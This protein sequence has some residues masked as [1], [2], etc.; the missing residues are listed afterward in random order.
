MAK[1]PAK[2]ELSIFEISRSV[3]APLARLLVS[4]CQKIYFRAIESVGR[5]KRD[6]LILRVE[7]ARDTLEEAKQ[8]FQ[9]ALDKFSALTRFDGAG[10]EDLYRQLKIEFDYS[11]AKAEA[12]KDRIDAVQDVAMALFAE[13][14]DELEQYSNRSLRSSSRQKLKLTQQHCAQLISAMRRAEA[15]IDPVL[16]VF[17]DQVLFLKHNLNANAI[18]S[19][20]NELVTMTISISGLITAMERSISRADAFVNALNGQRALPAG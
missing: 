4:G 8:Q 7:T 1:L 17:Q 5:H 14:E 16:R 15:K 6:I 10:L 19:L 9:S 3:I 18:A 13:W 11:R 12:V 2:H 20:E